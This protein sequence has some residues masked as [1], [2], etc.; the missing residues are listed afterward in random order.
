[1]MISLIKILWQGYNCYF[2]L[3]KN[4]KKVENI[5]QEISKK[6]KDI[7]KIKKVIA[8]FKTLIE[9]SNEKINSINSTI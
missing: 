5:L 6:N 2:D 7:D 3:T 9:N 1:M 8:N 4:K